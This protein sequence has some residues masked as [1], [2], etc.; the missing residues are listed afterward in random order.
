MEPSPPST[1]R[2]RRPRSR[3]TSLFSRRDHHA[4]TAMAPAPPESVMRGQCVGNAHSVGATSGARWECAPAGG[5]PG[6]AGHCSDAPNRGETITMDSS[7]F[8]AIARQVAGLPQSR[9]AAL[10]LLG[11]ALGTALSV[12][13]Q[14]GGATHVGCRHWKASCHSHE[15]C[16]SGICRRKRCRATNRGGC[17]LAD[18]FCAGGEDN[19]CQPGCE[20]NITTGK[21]PHCG[22]SVFCPVVEC[23]RDTDCGEP[24]AACIP[25]GK[26]TSCGSSATE[27]FC[28][29]PCGI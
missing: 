25:A 12:H 24:G 2:R 18:N 19:R 7:R 13:A 16:C 29:F 1:S 27:N 22:G 20:C 23:Q 17:R 6:D 10:R 5:P 9:R 4:F 8:D 15:Q 28:A 26:C 3:H 11:G 14:D 21:A